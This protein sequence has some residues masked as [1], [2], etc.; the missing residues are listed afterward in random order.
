MF[1]YLAGPIRINTEKRCINSYDI[2]WR[3]EVKKEL[4]NIYVLAKIFSPLDNN[5]FEFTK[6][7]LSKIKDYDLNMINRSNLVIANLIPYTRDSYS[8]FGTLY[9]I[10]YSSKSNKKIII[11][12][13][14]KL[15]QKLDIVPLYHNI[16]KVTSFKEIYTMIK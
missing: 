2:M 4:M 16:P 10:G 5:Y 7:N 14:E 9:E 3:E 6:E 8:C 1:I 15:K 12:C 13:E 11:V